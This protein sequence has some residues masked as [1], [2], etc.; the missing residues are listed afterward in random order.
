MEIGGLAADRCGC[1]FRWHWIWTVFA[2]SLPLLRSFD[3]AAP[4][5]RMPRDRGKGCRCF[6]EKIAIS[7]EEGLEVEDG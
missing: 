3:A 5:C 4:D 7:C 2:D 6:D 1:R